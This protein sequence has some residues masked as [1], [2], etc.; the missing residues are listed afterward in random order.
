MNEFLA[1]IQQEDEAI[2][3]S[4]E[5][6]EKEKETPSGSPAEKEPKE[7]APPSQGGGAKEAEAS[8]ENTPDVSQTPLNKQHRWIDQARKIKE[9]EEFKD[10][11]IPLLERIG[12]KPDKIES[13]A[14]P[15]FFSRLYGEDTEAWTLYRTYE[16]EQSGR[17][18]AELREEFRNDEK[19]KVEE[20][21]K[22]EAW[23]DDELQKLSDNGLKFDR[24]ELLNIALKFSPREDDG[25]Y[26]IPKAY[27]I[28]KAMNEAKASKGQISPS[29]SRVEEKKKIADITMKKGN[30]N[31]EKRDYK[32]S[33]DFKGKSFADISRE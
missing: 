2:N 30:A 23:L 31:E 25:N 15:L 5:Q 17:L 10:R 14:V 7:E 22:S 32:T 27:E 21:K 1:N 26:S 6:D 18:R 29:E 19:R 28:W 33:A 4:V 16:K 12:E 11:A 20:A 9:L 3:L 24:N 8:K 13:E